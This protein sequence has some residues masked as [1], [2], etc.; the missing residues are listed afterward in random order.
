MLAKGHGDAIALRDDSASCT[1]SQLFVRVNQIAQVL[2]ND[3]KLVPGGLIDLEFLCQYAAITGQSGEATNGTA[4]ALASL[5]IEKLND[6]ECGH[7]AAAYQ[8]FS[9]LMQVL[10][11]CLKGDPDNDDLPKGLNDIMC[12]IGELPDM[13][14]LQ[15]HVKNTAQTVRKISD[16][17]LR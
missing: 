2:V 4:K 7:I 14:T 12:K 9:G 5:N 11:L 6:G 15:A 10:R 13:A 16:R 8:L 1:Y 3:L 17:L